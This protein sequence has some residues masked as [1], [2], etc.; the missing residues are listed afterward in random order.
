[1]APETLSHLTEQ[2]FEALI[3]IASEDLT[4]QEIAGRMTITCG[5]AETLV[6]RLLKKLHV[7]GRRAARRYAVRAGLVEVTVHRELRA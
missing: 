3:L 2:E 5:S 6:H 4:N 1:M 7:S